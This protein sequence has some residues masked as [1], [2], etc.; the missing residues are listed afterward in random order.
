V[1]FAWDG[2]E[3][4]YPG[5]HVFA[6]GDTVRLVVEARDNRRVRW[7]GIHLVEPFDAADS[8]EI[9]DSSAAVSLG[10]DIFTGP[11][12]AGLLR[13]NGFARDD[14][15]Q[16]VEWEL[17]GTLPRCTGRFREVCRL[18]STPPF[19]TWPLT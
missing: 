11:A 3:V 12:L 6:A 17:R 4:T 9:T 16:R 10:V 7:V 2:S 1:V 13:I 14:L 15:G 8:V 5:A 19:A 18:L